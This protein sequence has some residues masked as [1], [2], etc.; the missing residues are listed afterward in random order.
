MASLINHSSIRNKLSGD[1]N[2]TLSMVLFG[3][4]G[5]V[6]TELDL[7]GDTASGCRGRR[8]GNVPSYLGYYPSQENHP[9]RRG[10]GA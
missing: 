1:G 2:A 8:L 9:R 6:D 10:D 5:G 4:D 7:S 3:D